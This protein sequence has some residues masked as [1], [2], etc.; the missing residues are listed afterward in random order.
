MA[1][2]F[3]LSKNAALQNSAKSL[4]IGAIRIAVTPLAYCSEPVRVSEC[5]STMMNTF[6]GTWNA[7]EWSM[8]LH[9]TSILSNTVFR[10]FTFKDRLLRWS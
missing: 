5:M 6:A 1:E 7:V 3:A 10:L 2:S 4:L 8:N 9:A